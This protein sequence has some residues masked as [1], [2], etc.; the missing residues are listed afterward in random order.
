MDNQ[1]SR[2]GI[3]QLK[4]EIRKHHVTPGVKVFDLV[5]DIDGERLKCQTQHQDSDPAFQK[6]ARDFTKLAKDLSEEQTFL[7]IPS[8]H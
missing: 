6:F 7:G 2:A 4:F 8:K 3:N 1:D 5:M